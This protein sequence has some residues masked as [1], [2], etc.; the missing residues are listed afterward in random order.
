MLVG[1]EALIG[2]D[3]LAPTSVKPIPKKRF[4]YFFD[5]HKGAE[6]GRKGNRHSPSHDAT[7]HCYQAALAASPRHRFVHD[8]RLLLGALS[9]HP[10]F[11]R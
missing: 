6:H 11:Y 5:L 1:D 10:P 3:L 4:F 7:G 2:S 9:A 8:R